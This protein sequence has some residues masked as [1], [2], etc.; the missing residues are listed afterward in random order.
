MVTEP[1]RRVEAITELG[2]PDPPPTRPRSAEAPG[3]RRVEHPPQA[4]VLDGLIRRPDEDLFAERVRDGGR[5]FSLAA[6]VEGHPGLQARLPA[7][8]DALRARAARLAQ[9]PLVEP[10]QRRRGR[11]GGVAA[12]EV[13]PCRSASLASRALVSQELP[14]GGGQPVRLGL[15]DHAV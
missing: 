2:R 15:D 5:R 8:Q 9:H 6:R 13:G 12:L 4:T 7:A 11:A 14:R 3:S 1:E 10:D